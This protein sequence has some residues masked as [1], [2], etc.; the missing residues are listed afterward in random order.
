MV[1]FFT[2]IKEVFLNLL[3][4]FL[5]ISMIAL[6]MLNWTKGLNIESMPEDFIAFKL[7]NSF[8]TATDKDEYD[9]YAQKLVTPTKIAIKTLEDTFS[10]MYNEENN[11]LVYKNIFHDVDNIKDIDLLEIKFEDFYNALSYEEYIYI[12]FLCPLSAIMNIE[13]DVF[14]SDMIIVEN[15]GD[16]DLYIKSK[17][18]YYKITLK[19]IS[20]KY[21]GETEIFTMDNEMHLEVNGIINI[22]DK[23]MLTLPIANVKEATID[24]IAEKNIA[25]T[26]LYNTAVATGYEV[27][28]KEKIYVNEYSTLSIR[29]DYIQF[30]SK[31]PRGN[32]YNQSQALYTSQMIEVSMNIFNSVYENIN[33]KIEAHPIEII[34]EESQTIVVLSG[35]YNG[36]EVFSTEPL[37][38]FVF[39][40]NGLSYCEIKNVVFEDGEEKVSVANIDLLKT[41]YKQ[42]VTYDLDGNPQRNYYFDEE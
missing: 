21:T 22:L 8:L 5:V 26:F 39:S 18:E 2:I 31:E 33:S 29:N 35:K 1:K 6:M 37:G 17:S 19:S 38:I 16:T 7:V 36:V 30:E 20:M 10:T 27:T 12:E 41:E 40:T 24:D 34:Y 15:E 4:L 13:S 11:S 3:M 23:N 25:V 9:G 42:I 14:V 32:I 28:Y